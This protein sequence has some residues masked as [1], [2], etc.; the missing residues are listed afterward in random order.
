MAKNT[1]YNK[2]TTQHV[3]NAVFDP[4]EATLAATIDAGDIEIGSVELKDADS[5]ALANIKAAN[6]ARTTATTVVAT[7]H[8]DAAG[9]VGG[10]RPSAYATEHSAMPA[11]P[12]VLPVGGEYRL[13]ADTYTDGD[14]V[15]EHF[16]VSGNKLTSLGTA[17]DKSFDSVT[18]YPSGC[19]CTTVDLATDA[20]VVVT[21]NAA[22][23]LGVYV[24]VV[25]SAHAAILKDSATAIVT[26]P[27][28]TA[29]GTN[30]NCYSATFATNI[31]VES[32]NAA[33]GTL[34]VFWRAA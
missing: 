6:T 17:L 19:T 11:T 21:A 15:V 32:D 1:A 5:T 27:A 13:A 10:I 14:T 9:A 34:L 20:D 24:S 26:L 2:Y 16:D 12:S 29:A 8:I 28:S 4:D 22:Y 3:F 18:A 25:M 33:T 30:I 23:L 31:T 7:Q